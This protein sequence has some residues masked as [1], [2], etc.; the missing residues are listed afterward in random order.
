MPPRR[1]LQSFYVIWHRDTCGRFQKLYVYR[2]KLRFTPL[3][4]EIQKIVLLVRFLTG[5]EKGTRTPK[6]PIEVGCGHRTLLKRRQ[7]PVNCLKE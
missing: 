5:W 4:F 6:R 7:N 3:T 1:H 2:I